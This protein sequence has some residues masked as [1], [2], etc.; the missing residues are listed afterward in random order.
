MSHI[1]SLLCT[2]PWQMRSG[3]CRQLDASRSR[4]KALPALHTFREAPAR[5]GTLPRL[6]RA[7]YTRKT[8]M[9][10]TDSR[11][12]AYS[13]PDGKPY[14]CHCQ[15]RRERCNPPSGPV[16]IA[17]P[18][19]RSPIWQRRFGSLLTRLPQTHPY[20]I[21]WMCSSQQSVP[22]RTEVS[23]SGCPAAMGE[24][25]SWRS[26]PNSAYPTSRRSGD[27]GK[28]LS[29]PDFGWVTWPQTSSTIPIWIRPAAISGGRAMP[30][31]CAVSETAIL[32]PSRAS[33]G[34]LA[35]STSGVNTR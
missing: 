3:L 25:C 2:V 15:S 16:E 6:L 7:H 22:C 19:S 24:R 26:R 9:R 18:C 20:G 11:Q 14:S 27:C 29:L 33:G 35:P 31:D 17:L 13:R 30:I 34:P 1:L 12:R 4:Q 28:R 5:P 23:P 21:L 8:N 32:P 10:Q